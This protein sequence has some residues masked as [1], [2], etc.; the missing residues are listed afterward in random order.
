MTAIKS[1]SNQE[2]SVSEIEVLN[3]K[4][5]HIDEML[6]EISRDLVAVTS[7][8]EANRPAIERAKSLMDPAARLRKMMGGTRHAVPQDG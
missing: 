3:R 2:I 1:D 8:I 7:F 5:D 4:L 6:H